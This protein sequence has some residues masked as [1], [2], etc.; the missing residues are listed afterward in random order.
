MRKLLHFITFFLWIPMILLPREKIVVFHAGSL[1]VPFSKIEKAF[2]NENPD[3]DV[4]RVIGGSRKLAR[5]ITDTGAYADI[6]ASADYTLIEEMLIP[7]FTNKVYKFASNE[8]VICFT[9]KS[10]YGKKITSNNWYKILSTSGVQW[11]HSEPDLDPCGYRTIIV[12]KLAEKYYKITGLADRILKN[13]PSKN[14]RPKSIELISL[15]K[16]GILDYAWEY[17]S[18]AVQHGLKYIRL[19][20][21]INLSSLKY[22]DFYSTVKVKLS[23]EKPG[24]FVYKSGKPIIYGIALLKHSKN[25]NFAK[26][27]LDF[28]LNKNKGGKI[29]EECGQKF[30]YTPDRE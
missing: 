9:E 19:P 14:V 2:E 21:K 24:K 6:F 13:R 17:R 12:I 4:Q 15:L 30:I 11:G 25:R 22:N 1:T 27:L 10:K 28:I 7:K 26:K 8:M 23:G 16:E 3:I 20:E 29:L 18:V 5:M